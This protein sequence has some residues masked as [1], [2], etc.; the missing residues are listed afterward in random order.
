MSRGVSG[1]VSC[2]GSGGD[3]VVGV[4]AGIADAGGYAAGCAGV[5]EGYADDGAREGVGY[6]ADGVMY[7]G[8]YAAGCAGEA[9]G[10]AAD[11]AG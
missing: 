10:Y 8:V 1:I 9:G 11:G 5:A 4:G 7:A 2:G 3:E 6:A